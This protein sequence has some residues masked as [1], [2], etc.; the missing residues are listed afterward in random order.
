M[1]LSDEY[2]ERYLQPGEVAFA[3]R[4]TR[5]HTLLGSCVSITVWHPMLRI[6]GMCHYMLSNRTGIRPTGVLDGRYAED[7]IALLLQEIERRGTHPQDYELKLFGGGNQFGT[8]IIEPALLVS[9]QNVETGQRLLSEHGFSVKALHLGGIG[10]R[11]LIFEIATGQV[12]VRHVEG[13]N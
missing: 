13:N 7:A 11:R 1:S 10:H 3:D 4:F 12:W 8:S 2:E 5:M 6:G 9:T